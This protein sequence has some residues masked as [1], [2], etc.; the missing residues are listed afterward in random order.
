[1]LNKSG[2]RQRLLG[3][4][5]ST[6]KS[7]SFRARNWRRFSLPSILFE[8]QPE[9]VLGARIARASRKAVRVALGELDADAIS[10]LLGRPNILKSEEVTKTLTAVTKALGSDKGP[11]GVLLPDGSVRVS[12]LTFET[13]PGSRKEQESLIRW[14][15]KPLLPFPVEDARLTFEVAAKGSEGVEAVVLAVRKSVVAE[16]ESLLEGLNGDLQLVLPTSAA[17]L[18]LLSDN[19]EE[20]N[21]LLHLSQAQLTVAA[22]GDRQIKLWRNRT[23]NGDTFAEQLTTVSEEAARTIAASHDHLG[24]EISRVSLCARPPVPEG[25]VEE[26]ARTISHQVELLAP[27]PSAVGAK[28]SDE[29]E[30]LLSEFGAT[31]AGVVANAV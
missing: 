2:L 8:V 4:K 5:N 30:K 24:L 29:E 13:L 16:Y 14:K 20:G 11:F 19:N 22:V 31:I 23:V 3:R 6:G 9:Y 15:M 21:L 7:H 25:W 28:L 27:D 26:L 12:I 18:P 10:P 1:M 17:L